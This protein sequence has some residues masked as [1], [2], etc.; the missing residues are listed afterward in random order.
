MNRVGIKGKG[1]SIWLGWFLVENH[2]RFA[3]LC[4]ILELDD[5][6]D[7]HLMK[8]NNL[9]ETINRVAWDGNWYLRAYY[10]DGTPLGSHRNNECQIDSLPQSWGVLS[11]SAPKMKQELAMQAVKE[12][13][14][15]EEDLLIK[16][17][18][19][20]FD[21]TQKDPGYIKGYPPGIRENGGQYTHAAIW[22][23]WA[24][25][26]L[27]QGDEAFKQFSYLNPIDHAKDI[28]SVNQYAV[29]PYVVAADIYSTQ[30]FI[31]HGGWTWYTGSSGW[32]YR[33]GIEAIL[34]FNL[35]GDHFTMDPCIPSDWDGFKFIYKKDRS[36]YII[37]VENPNHVQKGVQKIF[38]DGEELEDNRI[39]FQNE[40]REHKIRV[41]LG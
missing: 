38:M 14:V 6:A 37:E 10:D 33:L 41:S 26:H 25:T 4:K 30:P 5:L 32:L 9:Q 19:P 21:E 36:T 20:P 13:L 16:L 15:Q 11:G 22:A 8:A 24:L 40:Q 3:Q 1:E 28:S 12:H 18:N 29:E 27:G 7:Q 35:E 2:R 39:H 23:V 17:F 34:G 31:G